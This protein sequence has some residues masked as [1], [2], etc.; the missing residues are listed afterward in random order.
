[1]DAFF[2]SMRAYVFSGNFARGALITLAL[3]MLSQT[4]GIV[5]GLIVALARTSRWRAVRGVAGFYIWFLRGTPVLL[6]LI[7]VFAA[8]PQFGVRFS[9]FQSAVVALSLNEGAYMAEIIRAGINSVTSGQRLASRALGMKEWQV[10]RYVVLPQAL[11]VI[12]PPTG[13]QFIGMLK[14]SALASVISVQDLLLTAQRTAS[15]N[16]DYV[17]ALASA[18]VYYLALT[19]LFTFIQQRLERRLSIEHRRRI[20]AP[21]PMPAGASGA[22]TP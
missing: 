19:T 18:A 11:R 13:N 8:L 4:I 16:F 14:T 15:A 3:T 10:M 21:R 12:I 5:L 6:Q 17:P 2:E 22:V 1:L 20:R 9:A 7:F